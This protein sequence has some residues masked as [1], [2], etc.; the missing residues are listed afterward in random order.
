MLVVTMVESLVVTMVESLAAWTA[1]KSAV[2]WADLM[3]GMTVDGWVAVLA[4]LLDGW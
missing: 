3:V 2:T 4:V 1:A